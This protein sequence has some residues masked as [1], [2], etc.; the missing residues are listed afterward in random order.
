MSRRI[1]TVFIIFF[2]IP[3]LFGEWGLDVGASYDSFRGIPDGSWNGNTGATLSANVSLDLSNSIGLQFGG[4][5]G[6]YNWDGR[7]NVVFKNPNQ[8][9]QIG[10]VT[11]GAFRGFGNLNVGLVYDRLMTKNFSIF[12]VSPHI[13]QFRFQAGFAMQCDEVGVWGTAHLST[14]RGRAL[15]LPVA[16]RAI[17]QLNLYWTHFFYDYAK[18]TVWIGAPYR[19]SLRFRSGNAGTI[20]AGFSCR[21]NLSDRLFL[22]GYGTYMAAKGASRTQNRNYGSSVS[23]GV[24]YCFNGGDCT[25]YNP[26]YMSLANHSNFFVESN[27]NQ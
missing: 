4:S 14:W 11:A 5:Y 17:D 20:I 26:P 25:S 10:F 9:Q 22:D 24:T 23:I 8:M 18:T 6:A 27:A 16:F 13:D 15:G 3:S 7:G 1:A 12:S 21:A 19:Q 2:W